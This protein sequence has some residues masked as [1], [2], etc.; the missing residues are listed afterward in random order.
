MA[1]NPVAGRPGFNYR[2]GKLW[3]PFSLRHHVQTGSRAHPASYPVVISP[4]VKRP[5]RVTTHFRLVSRLRIRG[6]ISPLPNTPS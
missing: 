4:E 1:E 3:I 2:Q 5:E 6:A